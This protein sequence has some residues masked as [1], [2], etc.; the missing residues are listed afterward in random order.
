MNNT[1]RVVEI[2]NSIEGEGKR[3]GLP[4]TF[5][6]LWGCNLRCSYCDSMYAVEGNGYTVMSI[7]A[8][9]SKVHQLDCLAVTITGGEPL[10]H[11]NVN[12]LILLLVAEGYEVNIET[13]G[14]VTPPFLYLPNLFYTVDFKTISSGESAKMNISI[15]PKLSDKDVIKFVV[16]TE[17]DLNQVKNFV[18]KVETEA[19]YYI[20]PIFGMIEPVQIVEFIKKH[21]MWKCKVQLQLHKFIWPADMKGV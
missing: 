15:F 19:Q 8:I 11:S 12:E 5:I 10:I 3:A 2:F 13:N 17:E 20:S 21:K 4:C 9:L 7:D 18:D 16:G 14:S 6:R 1:M